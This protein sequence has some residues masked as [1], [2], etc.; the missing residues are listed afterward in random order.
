LL[1]LNAHFGI[2]YPAAAICSVLLIIRSEQSAGADP[3]AIKLPHMMKKWTSLSYI[4]PFFLYRQT[5]TDLVSLSWSHFPSLSHTL[6]YC[7]FFQTARFYDLTSA[8]II[9][10]RIHVFAFAFLLARI[11]SAFS[12]AS[13]FRDELD[14]ALIQLSYDLQ[15]P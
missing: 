6:V 10:F 5:H 8:S 3:C 13:H 11:F 4:A 12:G 9:M 1:P 14:S 2:R 15:L 7:S